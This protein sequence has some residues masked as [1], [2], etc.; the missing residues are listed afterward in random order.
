MTEQVPLPKAPPMPGA[1]S[2]GLADAARLLWP[3]RHHKGLARF[4]H[5]PYE[6]A[7]CWNRGRRRPPP[8]VLRAVR[9]AVLELAAQA[10]TAGLWLGPEIE[11]RE[12]E[13][14]LRKGFLRHRV[15]TS[16]WRSAPR[17]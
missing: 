7:R 11:R 14:L 16:E 3:G 17:W 15:E 12:R 5:V 2:P 1:P 4:A 13:S 10:G 9:H 8:E 6:T